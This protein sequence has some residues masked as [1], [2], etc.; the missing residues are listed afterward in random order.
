MEPFQFSLTLMHQ[1]HTD[2]HFAH[3][4]D[5]GSGFVTYL[6]AGHLFIF[7]SF[8]R[9][10][11][12]C[13]GFC[14]FSSRPIFTPSPGLTSHSHFA[15]S[16]S[17]SYHKRRQRR[18]AEGEVLFPKCISEYLCES[19]VLF[20]PCTVW[21]HEIP[22]IGDPSMPKQPTNYFIHPIILLSRPLPPSANPPPQ[23]AKIGR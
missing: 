3:R 7:C 9:A 23:T 13:D 1:C 17:A 6:S 19:C 8:Y 2:E 10:S 22:F 16:L 5:C 20:A 12:V 18:R 4:I 14:S 21:V 15:F 11:Q